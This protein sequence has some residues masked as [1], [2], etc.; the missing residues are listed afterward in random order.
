MEREPG[1]LLHDSVLYEVE[2]IED[3]QPAQGDD[4]PDG[5]L[6]V[7]VVGYSQDD[8]QEAHITLVVPPD[9]EDPT[10]PDWS[11]LVE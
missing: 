5:W 6:S 3:V 2:R 1:Y 9:P 7:T 10:R 8:D 11:A 4:V